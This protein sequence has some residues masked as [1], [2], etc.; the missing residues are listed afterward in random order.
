MVA[1]MLLVLYPDFSCGRKDRLCISFV[2][3]G[4]SL[5]QTYQLGPVAG[6]TTTSTELR[7]FF[8]NIGWKVLFDSGSYLGAWHITKGVIF[9]CSRV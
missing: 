1:S 2:Y 7:P 8:E 4:Y 5:L 6:K 9:H 3:T